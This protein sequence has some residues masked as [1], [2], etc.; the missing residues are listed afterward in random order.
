GLDGFDEAVQGSY[1][2]FL[3][4]NASTFFSH[5]AVIT[6]MAELGILGLM[7]LGLLLYRFGRLCW[8]LYDGAGV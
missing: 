3:P 5:T 6:V 8:R 7:V 2:H 1:N 4:P